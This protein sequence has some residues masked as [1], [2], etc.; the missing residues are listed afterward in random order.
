[1]PINGARP[2]N[3]PL[4]LF[5]PDIIKHMNKWLLYSS[6]LIFSTIGGYI[7][8]LWHAGLLSA[9]GIIGG[10]VGTIAG[11][12]IAFQVNNYVDF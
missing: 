5:T 10:I 7:P 9:S 3:L 4:I 6:V 11:I 8:S 2:T 1:V 12:W